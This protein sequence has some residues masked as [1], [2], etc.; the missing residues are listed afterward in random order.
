MSSP[1]ETYLDSFGQDDDDPDALLQKGL[2]GSLSKYSELAQPGVETPGGLGLSS[3]LISSDLERKQ[4]AYHSKMD[5]L[6][7]KALSKSTEISPTQ[8]FALSAFSVIPTIAGAIFGSRGS[9]PNYDIAIQGAKIGQEASAGYQKKLDEGASEDRALALQEYKDTRDESLRS[10]DIQ[11][12]VLLQ[13]LKGDDGVVAREFA[14]L[15]KIYGPEKAKMMITAKYTKRGATA[16]ALNNVAGVLGGI[17]ANGSPAAGPAAL[18]ATPTPVAQAP[19]TEAQAV[20]Q[21][22]A[23]ISSGDPVQIK[24]FADVS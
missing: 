12:A 14:D 22:K 10:L 1:F 19:I 16:D 7:K 13:Q 9:H 21:A 3:S 23:I 6:L 15:S 4:T 18:G 5:E 2:T 20:D 8:A 17:L 11:K 24:S